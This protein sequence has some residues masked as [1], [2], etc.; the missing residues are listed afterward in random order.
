MVCTHG[1]LT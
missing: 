1:N